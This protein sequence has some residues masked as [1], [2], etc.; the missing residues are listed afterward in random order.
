MFILLKAKRKREKSKRKVLLTNKIIST[1]LKNCVISQFEIAIHI[2]TTQ[3]SHLHT[4][5]LMDID[6]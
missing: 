1:K 3:C 6:F 2:I 4:F 5:I